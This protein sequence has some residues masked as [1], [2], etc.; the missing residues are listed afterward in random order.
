MGVVSS[1]WIDRVLL[2]PEWERGIEKGGM[3]LQSPSVQ[4][5]M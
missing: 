3:K 2:L 5:N 4:M 1:N